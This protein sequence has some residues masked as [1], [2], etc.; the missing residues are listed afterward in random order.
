VQIWLSKDVG[1]PDSDFVV[2]LKSYLGELRARQVGGSV[3]TEQSAPSLKETLEWLKQTLPIGSLGYIESHGGHTVYD[4]WDLTVWHLDS[5]TGVFGYI[6]SYAVP[7]FS[8]ASTTSFTVRYTVPLGI[9][10]Q[11]S[12]VL[13]ENPLARIQ[14]DATYVQGDKQLYQLLLSGTA[15]EIRVERDPGSASTGSGLTLFFTDEQLAQRVQ[16]AFLHAADLCRKKEA[17]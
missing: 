1:L 13:V 14:P 16:K 6:S 5:C 3:T 15:K 11:G 9:L 2:I 10:S 17:F 4:K 8:I 12:I 7:D